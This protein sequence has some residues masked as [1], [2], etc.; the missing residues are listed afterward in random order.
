[1]IKEIIFFCYGDSTN[2]STWSNVPYLFT[3][4]LSEQGVTIRRVDLLKNLQFIAKVYNYTIVNF[5]RLFY[6]KNQ[7]IYYFNRSFI[8]AFLVNLKIKQAVTKYSTADYCIFATFDFYN[9]F[10]KIPTLLFGDWTYKMLLTE[11]LK[12]NPYWFEKRFCRQVERAINNAQH[13]VSLFSLCAEYMKKD[14]PHA[15][16][17]YLG[18]NVIN[19]LYDDEISETHI[20]DM[21][22]KSYNLLFIG[23]EKYLDGAKLLV[24]AF[25]I[26]NL[27]ARYTLH[28]IGLER[29][30]F[31][32][33]PTNVL[34]YGYL[35]KDKKEECDLYYKLLLSTKIIIN[36]T[37]QWGGYSS[38][39]EAMYFYTPVIVSPYEEFV[40]EF[41]GNINFGIYNEKNDSHTLAI[42]IEKLLSNSDYIN[43]CINAHEKVKAYTWANY[44]TKILKLINDSKL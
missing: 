14:Y 24:G 34:C 3:K 27:N 39:V 36:P 4:S 28:I 13:A 9:K 38:I 5:L 2:A 11:R 22:R 43:M 33:L 6:P 19:S 31:D 1:M 10:N 18:E 15:N 30:D 42:N 20:L 23:G 26:L 25:N 21:K 37:P 41:G 17:T 44:V 40:N 29:K 8:F 35:R 12:R 16:I 7:F 32:E